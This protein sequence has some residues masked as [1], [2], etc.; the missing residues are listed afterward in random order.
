[1]T[2]VAEQA[3]VCQRLYRLVELA[4]PELKELF[5]DPTCLT[6]RAVLR[7]ATTA[8]QAARRWTEREE[9]I[10]QGVTHAERV[11]RFAASDRQRGDRKL[12]ID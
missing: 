9:V 11:G 3:K 5:D 7:I 10:V 4:S 1:M 2:L 8:R 12:R 6:A